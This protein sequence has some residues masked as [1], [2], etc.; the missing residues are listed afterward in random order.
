MFIEMFYTKSLLA[1]T[2]HSNTSSFITFDT[3]LFV[4]NSNRRSHVFCFLFRW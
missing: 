4:C 1:S 3:W 2:T